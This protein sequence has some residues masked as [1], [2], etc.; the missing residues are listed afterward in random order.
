MFIK[1][2]TTEFVFSTKRM[3]GGEHLLPVIWA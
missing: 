1:D 2:K 3:G